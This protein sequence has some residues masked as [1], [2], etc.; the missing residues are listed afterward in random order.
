MKKKYSTRKHQNSKEKKNQVV[1]HLFH[2]ETEIMKV[3]CDKLLVLLIKILHRN[4]SQVQVSL[5]VTAQIHHLNITV[6]L[7]LFLMF[8]TF[9]I[10]QSPEIAGKLNNHVLDY[11]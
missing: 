10:D 7:D 9:S 11:K 8:D 6:M 5:K 3:N 4:R 1:V 2:R